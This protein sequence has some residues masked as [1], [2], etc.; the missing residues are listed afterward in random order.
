MN[1]QKLVTTTMLTKEKKS[2]S[3]KK[4]SVPTINA[5]AIYKAMN[6]QLYPFRMKKFVF[7]HKS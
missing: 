2:I 5:T 7:P 1:T 6:Y 4:C 3:I